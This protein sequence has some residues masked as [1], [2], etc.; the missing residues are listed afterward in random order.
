[1]AS[2][3]AINREQQAPYYKGSSWLL[4]SLS[5]LEKDPAGFMETML[6][7]YQDVVQFRL[8]TESVHLCIHP[9][10]IPHVL[11]ENHMN[12]DKQVFDYKMMGSRLLGKGLLTNDGPFWLKQRRLSQPAFSHKRINAYSKIMQEC[13]RD[14]LEQWRQKD[15]QTLDMTSEMAAFTL[16]IVG[17]TLFGKDLVKESAEIGE[18]FS[19]AN[20]L[21]TRRL[22]SGIPDLVKFMTLDF[23][24]R[25]AAGGLRKVVD[26]IIEERK[27][28]EDQ[29]DDLLSILMQARDEEGRGMD[30]A[31]LRDEVLTLLLA[32]H[33]TTAN[34]LSW[35][36]HLLSLHEEEQ[37]HLA[38]DCK[39]KCNGQVPNF[40]MFKELEQTNRV[41]QETMR[42][43]PP[44]WSIARRCKEEDEIMGYRVKSNSLVFLSQLVTHRHPAFWQDP[45]NFRPSRFSPEESKGRHNYAFFPFGGGPRL[46]IGADFAMMEAVIILSSLMMEFKVE[47]VRDEVDMELL[48]TLRPKNGLPLRIHRRK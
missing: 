36:L 2:A 46:C 24:L 38:A 28:K 35:A 6:R 22:F 34:A 23:K 14:F 41:V 33:E 45:E 18:V 37:E 27:G 13:T 20:H 16:R 39:P 1:M 25:K 42:I 26:E 30:Y 17:L 8:A 44:A 10:A 43:Y 15:G 3:S 40:E 32:G 47:P 21:L 9:D 19:R 31:Q 5:E 7:N 48:I 12:F 4:G 11:H 29:Y